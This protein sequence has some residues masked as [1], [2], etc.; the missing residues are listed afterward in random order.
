MQALLDDT[1]GLNRTSLGLGLRVNRADTDL[2][3]IVADELEQLGRR[4][5]WPADRTGRS[6]DNCGRWDGARLQQ[7]LRNLVAN[8]IKY[9]SAD[10]PVRVAVRCEEADVC[11]RSQQQRARH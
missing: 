2:G 6:P 11:P 7:L 5:L 8:A 3:A 1:G 4:I 10:K 9:R